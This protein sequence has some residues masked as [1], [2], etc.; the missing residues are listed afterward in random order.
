MQWPFQ[1][2]LGNIAVARK[3]SVWRHSLLRIWRNFCYATGGIMAS[4]EYKWHR[5]CLLRELSWI[6]S[7]VVNNPEGDNSL[8]GIFSLLHNTLLI[9]FKHVTILYLHSWYS[10]CL[11]QSYTKKKP[12]VY[13]VYTIAYFMINIR[14]PWGRL[15]LLHTKKM[16]PQK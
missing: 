9:Q 12:R 10:C 2:L 4:H 5:T 15:S 3:L 6:H 13:V 8:V 1:L 16:N 7:G 11:H 14:I